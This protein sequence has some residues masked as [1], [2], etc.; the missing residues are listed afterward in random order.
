MVRISDIDLIRELKKNARIT[1]TELAKKYNVSESA[2]RKRVA[3]LIDRRVI[4]KFTVDVNMRKLGF[5][6]EALIGLDTTPEKLMKVI[7]ELK[8]DNM[9]EAL[10]TSA[11]DHMIMIHIYFENNEKLR[12]YVRKLEYK[13]GVV[14]VC[15]AIILEKIK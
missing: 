8:E 12:E 14:K 3:K 15:P 9:I 7:D 1:F 10:Y 4:K 5:E 6:V 13:D 11:G 2:I